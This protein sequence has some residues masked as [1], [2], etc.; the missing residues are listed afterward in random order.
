MSY[1]V[2]A[3]TALPKPKAWRV[4][5]PVVSEEERQRRS[6]PTRRADISWIDATGEV[7][8]RTIVVPALPMFQDAL[9][10]F[11]QGTLI[12]TPDG[13]VAIEDLQPGM[14]VSTAEGHAQEI[15]WIGSMIILPESPELS[16]PGLKLY[17]VTDGGYGLDSTTPDL[18]LGPAARILPGMF[19]TGSSSPLR[20]IP[21]L[22]DGYSTIEIRP[23]SPVRVFHICLGAHRL[24]YANGVLAE[25]Y[26]PGAN[27]RLYV[28][29]EMYEIFL[30]TFPHIDNEGGFG[31]QI[32]QR[33]VEAA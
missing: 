14:K 21:D 11:A 7:H 19:A 25:S 18:L 13:K 30:R 8:D 12:Q 1:I 26:H 3:N 27:S 6:I 2:R 22:A 16:L 17:R 20:N 5:Q 32:H 10:A 31:P 15:M 24:I 28:S 33:D 9:S 29:Q 23:V 4:N